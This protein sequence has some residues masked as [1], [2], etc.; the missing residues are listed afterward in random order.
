MILYLDL[1][2]MLLQRNQWW[3]DWERN[4]SPEATMKKSMEA[5]NDL[6]CVYL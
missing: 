6:I 1:Q 5:R 3:G 2:P 4:G